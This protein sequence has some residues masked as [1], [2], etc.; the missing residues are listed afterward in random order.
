MKASLSLKIV[1]CLLLNLLLL[2]A[3][4]LSLLLA[5]GGIGWHALVAGPAGNPVQEI[6]DMIVGEIEATDSSARPQLL[7]RLGVAYNAEVFVFSRDG[8]LIAGSAERPIP[9]TISSR[10]SFGKRPPRVDP[11]FGP[12]GGAGPGFLEPPYSRDLRPWQDGAPPGPPNGPDLEEPPQPRPTAAADLDPGERERFPTNRTLVRSDSPSAYWIIVRTL[13]SPR[14]AARF[15][16][17]PR[18]GAIVFR[19]ESLWSLFRLMGL[20]TSAY[21]GLGV[22]LLSALVWFPLLR[23]ITHAIG[24]LTKA[25]QRIAEGRFDT[26][27]PAKRK[28][29]LGHLGDSVN[30]MAERLDLLV[31]GQRRF[32][33][34]IAHELC[35]PIARLQMAI[36]ILE[37]RTDPALAPAISDVHEE[38]QQ[39]ADLV[40][41]LLAFTKAGMGP[42]VVKT[43]PVDLEP[44]V[45]QAVARETGTATVRWEIATGLRVVAEPNLIARALSNLLRNAVR[46]AGNAGPI[47]VSADQDDAWV[48]VRVLD[49]GPGVDPAAL[50]S[51]GEP[52][53]RPD[54]ARTREGGGVGLG[55]AI[56]KSAVLACGGAVT[57]ANRS[58]RG[59]AVEIRLPAA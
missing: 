14:L 33:G 26:R 40:N 22:L 37:E 52:F 9:P 30:R 55:L 6:A 45:E 29:E 13:P 21:V 47:V 50:G 48:R 36:G 24:D 42:R 18:P 53:F 31:A 57:F 8:R 3:V 4:G 56:V 12:D 27:V 25:T 20:T 44:L 51:L 58:P 39:M 11:S 7:T 16:E 15:E 35:S 23:G 54:A 38:V 17:G 46:Y 41:D 59:F 28:D 1:L 43:R 5:W 2:A 10:L 49:D 34:D 32:L 19:V